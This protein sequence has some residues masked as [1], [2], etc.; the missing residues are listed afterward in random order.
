[1]IDVSMLRV[2]PWP[3]EVVERSTNLC[4]VDGAARAGAMGDCSVGTGQARVRLIF[5]VDP[6]WASRWTKS[7]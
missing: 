6:E 3:T 2:S 5:V 1:M 7:G 4:V